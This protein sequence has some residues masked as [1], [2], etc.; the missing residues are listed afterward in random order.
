MDRIPLPIVPWQ[1]T[2][3]HW[4]ALPC[5]H[6]ATGAIH[7]LSVLHR[8]ARAAL[9]FVAAAP[10]GSTSESSGDAPLLRPVLTVDGE[11]VALG[12]AGMAWERA[13]GWLPTFT[14]TPGAL[15]IRGMVFCP[16]GRDA[17]MAG[18]VY[19]FAIENRGTKARAV[20]LALVGEGGALVP[21]VRRARPPAGRLQA[22]IADGVVVLDPGVTPGL[23]AFALAADGEGEVHAGADGATRIARTVT[24]QPGAREELA[25]YIAAGPERDG[26]IATSAAMKRRGWQWLLAATRDALSA[27]QQ[28]TGSESLD[29]LVNQNLLFAYFYAVGRAL[30]DA[31]F[32]IMRTRVP[33]H[34]AGVTMRDWDALMMTLPA[35]QLADPG[36][37]RELLLRMCE[38]HGYAPGRGTHY[39]DGTMFEPAFSLEG[40]AAYVLAVDRYAA[41]AKDEQIVDDPVLADTLYLVN[42]ELA[43]RRHPDLALYSTEVT[44]SGSVAPL[45]YTA[46]G[47]AV[48]A[49]ALDILRRTLDE[50]TAR[51]VPDGEAVRAALQRSFERSEAGKRLLCTALDLSGSESRQDDAVGSVLWLPLYGAIAPDDAVFRRT[52]RAHA[53]PANAL[54]TILARLCGPD[55][56]QVLEWL[57]R[58]PLDGGVA[59][60]FVDAE[61]RATANG[62]DAALAGLL[63]AT[64]C[65]MTRQQDPGEG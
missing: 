5:I 45:P 26:A 4:L 17:D 20:S 53:T 19:T 28:A 15:L 49:L 64:V 13:L 10:A 52:A 18:A 9:E 58:A 54:S 41:E 8:G 34:S 47:N 60:E 3:N 27:L 33:W 65:S 11:T 29:R 44:L 62:G 42:D 61:G 32:Y 22:A 1:L 36:L 7:R 48:V 38:L 37:A 23:A 14:C 25:F 30:D 6:P 24:I 21:R 39:F 31:H 2:G 50:E 46:H 40:A 57:R 12:A 59:A 51:D 56:V 55:S 43:E 35:V 63:A 16:F